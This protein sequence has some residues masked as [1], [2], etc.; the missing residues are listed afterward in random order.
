MRFTI[1][2][3]PGILSRITGILGENNISIARMIQKEENPDHPVPVVM[4]SHS[5]VEEDMARAIRTIN[6]LPEIHSPTVLI[7]AL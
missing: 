2:D 4:I 5:A 7:R 6:G 3:H 1:L